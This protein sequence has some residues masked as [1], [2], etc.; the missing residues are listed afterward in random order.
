[1]ALGMALLVAEHHPQAAVTLVPAAVA[2]T[3]LF[4]VF[5]P[6]LTARILTRTR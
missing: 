3:V 4:E 5:G 1:V 2:G 6:L